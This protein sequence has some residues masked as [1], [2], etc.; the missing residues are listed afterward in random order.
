MDESGTHDD[1][2]VVTVSAM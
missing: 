2:Q 1:S